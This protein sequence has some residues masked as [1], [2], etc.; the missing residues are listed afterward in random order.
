M[1]ELAYETSV[2]VRLADLDYFGIVNNAVYATY[3]EEARK[4]FFRDVVG[5]SLVDFDAVVVDLSIQYHRPIE[6]VDAVDVMV[7][8]ERLGTSSI[9]L[10]YEVS[11]GA[12]HASSARTTQVCIDRE[13]GDSQ[14]IPAAVRASLEATRSASDESI[15]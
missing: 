8:V 6:A 5:Q 14:A 13:T 15:E 11:S 3:L 2:P 7:G 10:A 4:R 1:T 9:E 12:E